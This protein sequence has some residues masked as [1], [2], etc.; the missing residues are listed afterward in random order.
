[1]TIVLE[2]ESDDRRIN[3][4][5]LVHGVLLGDLEVK[6]HSD[7]NMILINGERWIVIEQ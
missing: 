7:G 5:G 6:P 1:M 2:R 3:F 4:D